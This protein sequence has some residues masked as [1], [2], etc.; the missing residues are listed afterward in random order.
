MRRCKLF[1]CLPVL[2]L[3]ASCSRDPR[4]QAQRYVDN[5]NKFFSKEKYKEAS[6]MYR[7]ALQKDARFGEAYYRLALTDMKMA[8]YGDAARQ[9]R[10][11]VELQPNNID[12]A[13][14]L[15]DIF[16]MAAPGD[17]SH[18]AQIP[19]PRD[20]RNQCPQNQRSN[21]HF[22]QPQENITEKFQ[23][24]GEVR[25]I[26]TDLRSQQHREQNPV[27]QRPAAPP[28]QRDERQPNPAH[29]RNPRVHAQ[30][31]RQ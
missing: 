14:K 6:I 11:A 13:I 22:D 7:R 24:L 4:A 2:L 18:A 29:R 8:A 25:P 10:R 15:S 23:V 28:S 27:R 16:L 21:D 30:R 5:G 12:A 20:A 31:Q 17:P 3:L 9:L 1:A 26:D 19:M